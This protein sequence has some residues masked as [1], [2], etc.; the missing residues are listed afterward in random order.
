MNAARRQLA[1]MQAAV[2]SRR[3]DELRGMALS[4]ALHAAVLAL[5]VIGPPHLGRELAPVAPPVPVEVV[6]YDTFTQLTDN[7]PTKEKPDQ[8]Q[9]A[10][11]EPEPEPADPVPVPPPVTKA[12]PPE[13]EPVPE[14]V[15]VPEPAPPV[16]AA[17]PLPEPAPAPV[18]APEPEPVPVPEPE[19]VQA[20]PPPEPVQAAPIPKAKPKPPKPA[21][22]PDQ[23]VAK[24]ADSKPTAARAREDFLSSVLRNLDNRQPTPPTD[25]A[26]AKQL[27]RNRTEATASSISV[28]TRGTAERL[29][30]SQIDALRRHIG[31][32]WNIDAGARGIAD[33]VA[34]VEITLD[35]QRQV[36]SVRLL[37]DRARYNTDGFYRSFVE[38]TL[39]AV[40]QASPLT[41]LPLDGYQNWKTTI[42]TFSPRDM[43]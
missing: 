1:A 35:A 31:Q 20:A 3:H 10:V 19:P 28:A 5:I 21:P 33:M 30:A 41:P 37:D 23:A 7:T 12:P 11:A 38:R 25:E 9:T 4:F 6:D 36:T 14:P 26:I 18:A 43:F 22:Q 32:Y 27:Q 16:D 24:P 39:R 13:P 17:P 2:I 29:T 8:P 15:P 40:R 34:V 42:I